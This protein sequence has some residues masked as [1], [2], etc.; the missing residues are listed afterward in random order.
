MKAGDTCPNCKDAVLEDETKHTPNMLGCPNCGQGFPSMSDTEA[1]L[2]II[3]ALAKEIKTDKR[4]SRV[5]VDGD[6]K[7]AEVIF[8]APNGKQYV[9]ST[10]DIREYKE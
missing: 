4:F 7:S 2:S 5:S 1:R 3:Y 9:I 6:H 10:E 8:T